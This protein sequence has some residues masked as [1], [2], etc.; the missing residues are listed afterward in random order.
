MRHV[1][2]KY[3]NNQK[4]MLNMLTVTSHYNLTIYCT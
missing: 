4:T 1:K 3:V 2:V